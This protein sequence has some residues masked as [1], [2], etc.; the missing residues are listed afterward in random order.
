MEDKQITKNQLRSIIEDGLRILQMSEATIER[1]MLDL[2][3][4]V[5][6]MEEKKVEMYSECVGQ[7]FLQSHALNEN[8]SDYLKSRRKSFIRILDTIVNDKPY[9]PKPSRCN[10]YP[11]YGEIGEKAVDYINDRNRAERLSKQ[12][13]NDYKHHLSLF[14]ERMYASGIDC[15]TLS[16]QS[17]L[18]FVSSYQNSRPKV[19]TI[20]KKF[21]LYLYQKG[22]V[23]ND[24]SELFAGIREQRHEKLPSY[25]TKEEIMKLQQSVDRSSALGKRNYA[26]IL[27]ASRLGMR[28]SDIRNLTFK[29]ID[30]DNNTINLTQYKTRKELTLPL[31][32]E[33]GDAIIDYVKY[34][35]PVS[36]SKTIFLSAHPPYGQI[37]ASGISSIVTCC[38]YEANIEYKGRHHSAHALRHS[39]A[40]ALMNNGVQMPVISEALGHAETQSTMYYLGIDVTHLLECSLA[41]P[42]INDAFYTQGGGMLY[43]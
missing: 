26:I 37:S 9:K 30:W 11:L 34:G 23:K 42:P 25:Y 10:P 14:T 38:I 24:L 7:A 22:F 5:R 27:L 33:V 12:T 43:E 21:L 4:L 17:I 28:S 16:E 19:I 3:A 18:S 20:V 39:L 29:E 41:V 36:K 2:R 13:L 1:R 35:R 6:Y 40:T 31:L 32:A 15:K 8:I